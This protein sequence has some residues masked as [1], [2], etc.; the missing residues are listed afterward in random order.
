[1]TQ[2]KCETCGVEFMSKAVRRFCSVKCRAN[3]PSFREKLLANL[4]VEKTRSGPMRS[5]QMIKCVSCDN[6]IYLTASKLKRGK[7]AC[8][9]TCWHRWLSER[10]DKDIALRVSA[11]EISNYDEFL[12]AEKLKCPLCEWA[13]D[14]LSHHLNMTHHVSAA[15]FKELFGFNRSTSLVSADL[16]KKLSD[17]DAAGTISTLNWRKAHAARKIVYRKETIEHMRKMYYARAK[18]LE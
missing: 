9:R 10:F 6:E 17:R 18:G 4:S 1:M 8:S 2:Y 12:S 14:S 7:K 16:R 5:G 3:H 11:T 13:G 15:T